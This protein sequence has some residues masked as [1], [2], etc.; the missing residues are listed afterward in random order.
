MK[1]NNKEIF[2]E[3]REYILSIY[4]HIGINEIKIS[5]LLNPN[6]LDEIKTLKII[7]L[8]KLESFSSYINYDYFLIFKFKDDYYFCDTE[9]FPSLGKFSLVKILDFNSCLRKDKIKNLNNIN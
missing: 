3:I 5:S 9:L 4:D 7:K 2:F 6:I 8:D 1:L